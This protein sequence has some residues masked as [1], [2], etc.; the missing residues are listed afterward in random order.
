MTMSDDDDSLQT[1][2]EETE[3]FDLPDE[4]FIAPGTNQRDLERFG[5]PPSPDPY[6][7]PGLYRLWQDIIAQPLKPLPIEF[8]D[9]AGD[10]DYFQRAGPLR[11]A[12]RHQSSR[13]WSGAS[14]GA[15]DG[16]KFV[17]I[18]GTWRVPLVFAL[19][20][21]DDYRSSTWIGL[22]GQRKY[23]D[24]TLPQIGTAQ[25]VKRIGGVPTRTTESW[26]QWW[27]RKP[28]S[29][30]QMPVSPGDVVLAW[31]TV[32]NPLHVQFFILNLTAPPPFPF[33]PFKWR[34]PRVRWPGL[35]AR[36]RARVS[37]ATAEWVMERPT[38]LGSDELYKLPDYNQPVLATRVPFPFTDCYA[39][40]MSVLGGPTREENLLTS[41][42]INMFKTHRT[43]Y[44]A[45]KIS[46]AK[47]GDDHSFTTTY[48][49]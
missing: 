20:P 24:S 23:V 49:P 45:A 6:T 9:T 19:P 8:V 12:A 10:S 2:N 4:G 44:S 34:S 5:V 21:N 36:V 1:I 26:V 18:A 27:P 16:R 7:E 28:V 39:S 32:V 14:I 46:V 31:M 47:R 48:V 25:Y 38:R 35:P 33:A 13:N 22:D 43:P 41:T 42:L 11:A 15:H 30:Y 37:G 17:S 29:I 40:S 3:R